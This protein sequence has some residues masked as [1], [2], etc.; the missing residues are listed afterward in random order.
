MD[1]PLGFY[2]FCGHGR[3][4]PEMLFGLAFLEIFRGIHKKTTVIADSY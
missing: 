4:C 3:G 1:D 2:L